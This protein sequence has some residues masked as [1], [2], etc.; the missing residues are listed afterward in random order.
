VETP[1]D[2]D[3]DIDAVT[4]DRIMSMRADLATRR[5]ARRKPPSKRKAGPRTPRQYKLVKAKDRPPQAPG[6]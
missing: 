2:I 4:R 1:E 5:E 3:E 6:S